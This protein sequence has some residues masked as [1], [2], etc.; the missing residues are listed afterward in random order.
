MPRIW[1]DGKK[2]LRVYECPTCKD[3]D[4]FPI[5]SLDDWCPKCITKIDHA[6][7]KIHSERKFESLKTYQFIT[8]FCLP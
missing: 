1:Y 8:Q 4:G 6:N 7:E 2:S 3:I 5:L